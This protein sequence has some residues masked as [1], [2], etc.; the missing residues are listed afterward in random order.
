MDQQTQRGQ[1]A[2]DATPGAS[3][4]LIVPC[5]NTDR[6]ADLSRL[7]GSIT[8]QTEQLDELIVVVQQSQDL[9]T[10]VEDNLPRAF[11][12]ASQLVYI[13]QAPQVS[14]AR[15]AGVEVS[16]GDIVAFADDDAVLTDD[17]VA[18]TREFYHSNPDAIGVAGAILPLWDSPG[19]EW[20]PRELYWTVSCTYWT[21]N[22][23][24]PVRNG[25]GAN[26]SFR[27]E[28]FAEGRRFNEATGI[29]GWGQA[30][31]RGMG[32]EEPELSHLVTTSTGRQILYVPDIRVWHRVRPYRLTTRSLTRRAYWE[33][34]FK[35]WFVHQHGGDILG[36]EEALL[37][38]IWKATVE[39]LRLGFRHPVIA[40]RQ[41]WAVRIVIL[42]VGF[43]YLHGKLRMLGKP[44]QRQTEREIQ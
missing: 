12:N 42:C 6:I 11:I 43:G 3:I 22:I 23:P 44:K 15:N 14:R 4:S 17:W 26:M 1:S 38:A 9:K 39:R 40:T 24:L 13:E 32:G 35:A 28:A 25:Y 33:G 37:N 7:L 19:M 16:R 5:Y 41:H 2:R 29:S 31:W 8:R 20:F 36:T 34:R 21:S 10:W 18:R 30:G 27:K